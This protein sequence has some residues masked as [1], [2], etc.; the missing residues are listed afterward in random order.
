MTEETLKKGKFLYLKLMSLIDSKNELVKAKDITDIHI[1]IDIGDCDNK[2]IKT[3]I[4]YLEF[5]KLKTFLLEEIDSEITK[6]QKEFDE[7]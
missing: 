5:N 4:Q 1:T 3:S 2:Y 7:L 6:T